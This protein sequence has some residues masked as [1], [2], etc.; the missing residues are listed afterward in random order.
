[1]STRIDF[2]FSY[3]IFAWYLAYI[4]KLT[5]FNPKWG[6][7][8]GIVENLVFAFA[9]ALYGC[10]ISSIVTFLLVNMILKGLP[11]YTIYNTKSTAKDIYLLL[12]LF[13]IY[14]LWTHMNGTTVM[15]Y[16]AKMFQSI[17]HGKNETPAFW[18][19]SQI[20]GFF[21]KN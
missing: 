15:Q 10:V 6:L 16:N 3:W 1:M 5:T 21:S 18:A 8:L 13:A 17:M 14:T 12:G 4:A 19:I 20:R 9:L 11:L 7:I 2:T